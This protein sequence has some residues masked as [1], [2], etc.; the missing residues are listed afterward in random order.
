V[1]E[2]LILVEPPLATF[3]TRPRHAS[4]RSPAGGVGRRLATN[5][6]R[7]VATIASVSA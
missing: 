1:A 4:A 6:V 3:A 7:P 2:V 5:A